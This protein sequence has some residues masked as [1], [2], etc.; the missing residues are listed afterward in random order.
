MV[1]RLEMAQQYVQEMLEQRDD[2]VA[3]FV[4]GSVARGDATEAS[5]IDLGLIVEGQAGEEPQRGGI[6]AWREG[7]YIEA[8]LV[9]RR[10]Y[11]DV[12][13]VLQHQ[14]AA[15]HMNDG[16]I[17]YDPRGTFTRVQD[18]VRAAYMQPKHLQSK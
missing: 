9:P 10:R 7:V 12:E 11:D 2:I 17:L 6:D 13:N 18:G 14:F 15:T 4:V 1:D 5:D 16:L 8:A 3:A